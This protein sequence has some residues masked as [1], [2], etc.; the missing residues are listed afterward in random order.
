MGGAIAGCGE[1]GEGGRAAERRGAAHAYSNGS[2]EAENRRPD[3]G[4]S[5]ASGSGSTGIGGGT[6]VYLADRWRRKRREARS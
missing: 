4:G 1:V 5:A 2:V 3:A 6:A